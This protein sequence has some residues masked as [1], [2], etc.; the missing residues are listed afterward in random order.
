MKQTPGAQ[1]FRYVLLFSFSLLVFL[2]ITGLLL[3]AFRSASEVNLNPFAL[4][5][6]LSL[7]N[8]KNA[9]MVGRFGIFFKNSIIVAVITV[10]ASVFLSILTGY[11]FAILPLPGKKWLYP[12]VLLGYMV[13]FEAA[14]IPLYNLMNSLQLRD[15]YWALILP[16]IGLSVSFGTLWLTSSFET[17]PQELIDSATMDGSSR[18]QTLWRILVPLSTPSLTTLVVLI[19]MWT[20]NEFLLALVMI[21]DEGLRTLPVGLAF[22]QGRYTSNSPLLAAGALIVAVPTVLVYILFQRFFIRG[23]LGGAV[24]G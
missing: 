18:W 15:T 4:P 10:V 9:W 1:I 8:I 21:Q 17:I 11:A 23:M 22:F 6:Q 24:K 14:I 19:F 2:P 20:W 16:Q 12:L 13:P 3:N 7:E 5:S